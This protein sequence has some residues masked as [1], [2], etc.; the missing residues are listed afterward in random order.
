MR[1]ASRVIGGTAI[2]R[3]SKTAWMEPFCSPA[4]R[5]GLIVA[6]GESAKEAFINLMRVVFNAAIKDLTGLNATFGEAQEG[7]EHE[8]SGN[9]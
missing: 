8:R 2:G 9:A 7:P 1:C 4:F 5:I 6:G 3:P